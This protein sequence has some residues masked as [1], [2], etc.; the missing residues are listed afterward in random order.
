MIY[1][2]KLFIL[3]QIMSSSIVNILNSCEPGNTIEI[4]YNAG[5]FPGVPRNVEFISFYYLSNSQ[6]PLYLDAYDKGQHK[7]FCVDSISSVK[8]NTVNLSPSHVKNTEVWN[9]GNK[10]HFIYNKNSG[11]TER[12]VTFIKY[13]NPR[14][15]TIV[16]CI[17]NGQTKNFTMNKIQNPTIIFKTFKSNETIHCT[18]NEMLKLKLI[19]ANSKIQELQEQLSSLSISSPNNNWEHVAYPPAPC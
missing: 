1:N 15:K 7:T 13:L 18:E 6:S 19:K 9:S 10:I 2:Y 17:E 14:T 11:P 16:Q 5:S 8:K 12:N 4:I 3:S